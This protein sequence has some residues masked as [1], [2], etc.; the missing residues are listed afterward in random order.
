MLYLS[1]NPFYGRGTVRDD[2]KYLSTHTMILQRK[3][4]SYN[5]R[6]LQFAR[7]VVH[8]LKILKTHKRFKVVYQS[9]GLDEAQSS[10]PSKGAEVVG[11]NL[12]DVVDGNV[13]QTSKPSVAMLPRSMMASADSVLPSIKNFLAKP[14]IL[15]SGV[16]AAADNATSFPKFSAFQ[17]LQTTLK[18]A[19]LQGIFAIKF[20]TVWTLM[21]NADKFS[22]GYYMMS[23]IPTGGTA[24]TTFNDIAWNLQHAMT[25]VQ[26]TQLPNVRLNLACDTKATL[27]CPWMSCRTAM[28]YGASATGIG[29]PY[30]VYLTPYVPFATG[31]AG[32]ANASFVLYVHYE[33]V[34]IFG[35]TVPQSS[36]LDD[37]MKEVDDKRI[38][39]GMRVAA[40]SIGILAQIPMLSSI[41]TP[42][43]WFTD[44]LANTIS[45]FGYSKPPQLD[46]PTRVSAN[47][48]IPYFG[49]SNSHDTV[50][51]MS[52]K[53][54]NHVQRLS[55]FAASDMDE[56]SISFFKS[57][58]SAYA[59]NNWTNSRVEG[60]LLF[61]I[62]NTPSAF[63]TNYTDGV[64]QY[65]CVAPIKFLTYQ[66]G[67][68]RGSIKYHFTIVK[69]PMHSG[70][71]QVSFVPFDSDNTP[72]VNFGVTPFVY[73]NIF[74]IREVTEFTVTVPYI[75]TQNW[76][77]TQGSGS[78]TGN[79]YVH[80]IDPLRGPASVNTT[81]QIITEVSGGDDFEVEV[82]IRGGVQYV[83]PNAYQSALETCA[84]FDGVIGDASVVEASNS[85]PAC[86]GETC[87]S[88]LDLLKRG[89]YVTQ[90]TSAA[91]P[92]FLYQICIS[93]LL[94]HPTGGLTGVTD[95]D[96]FTM[97]APM[98]ALQ[99]GGMRLK[100]MATQTTPSIPYYLSSYNINSSSNICNIARVSNVLTQSNAEFYYD[101]ANSTHTV[102]QS[103]NPCYGIQQPQ[104]F[105]LPSFPTANHISSGTVQLI[106]TTDI[107]PNGTCL[108]GFAGATYPAQG[109]NIWRSVHD[110]FQLGGFCS[111]PPLNFVTRP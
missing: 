5:N 7:W 106:Q 41:A 16:F 89:G 39:G 57:I 52:L 84:A 44:V 75:S 40:K 20:T 76:Q 91:G 68:W 83:T 11:G 29:N 95:Y 82:P 71:I 48:T 22:Q 37:V 104:Y 23:A 78:A 98:F 24:P 33:D 92:T 15:L 74:D 25:V 107:D 54:D 4:L 1:H 43:S 101:T 2:I 13:V 51:P 70:R 81:I 108:S 90:P 36:G 65:Y 55:G 69:T 31:T 80:V 10:A 72:T 66:F 28:P 59:V 102:M 110:D 32:A 50:T 61:S 109:N 17:G 18:N 60:D 45:S 67:Y 38:S 86:I 63:F 79:L 34:E 26:R 87:R 14:E 30:N 96:P 27:R 8:S 100:L 21:V 46:K 56:T 62:S 77:D 12:V 3:L 49:S 6:E 94:G 88:I 85:A 73:R 103:T 111:I 9:S 64:N 42:V 99:R 97:W 93:F 58:I 35:E 19:K 53:V 47:D 105:N